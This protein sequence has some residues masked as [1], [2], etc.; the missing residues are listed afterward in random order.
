[1][2]FESVYL[3]KDSWF[4]YRTGIPMISDHTSY[5]RS[6]RTTLKGGNNYGADAEF[7]EFWNNHRNLIRFDSEYTLSGAL[8]RFN[9]MHLKH[10][11]EDQ[12]LD[13]LIACESTLLRSGGVVKSSI[14]SSLKL[15]A[16]MLL[17]GRTRYSRSEIRDIFMELYR[18]RGEIV[19]ENKTLDTILSEGDFEEIPEEVDLTIGLAREMLASILR[20]YMAEK[21][22]NGRSVGATNQLIN[23]AINEA[24]YPPD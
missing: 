23:E 10:Y 9:E 8:R 1:M 14:T 20:A 19:H 12:I 11:P 4:E 6:Q 24:P 16:S 5:N 17:D 18:L 13:C 22:Q 21:L 15:F 7:A 2:I 3:S